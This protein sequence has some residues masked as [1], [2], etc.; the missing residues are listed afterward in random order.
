[1]C[2]KCQPCGRKMGPRIPLQA[3]RY[4]YK[5]GKLAG[6]ISSEIPV[7]DDCKRY[8]SL[9]V[10][11]GSLFRSIKRKFRAVTQTVKPQTIGGPVQLGS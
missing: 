3:H 10:S 9:G 1:M 7:C 11:Y 8:L 2:W 6:N 4:Y 5:D